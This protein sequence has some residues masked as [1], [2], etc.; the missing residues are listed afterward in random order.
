MDYEDMKHKIVPMHWD[1]FR[2]ML[3]VNEVPEPVMVRYFQIKKIIDKLSAP[4]SVMDLLRMAM[5]VGFNLE[6]GL[7]DTEEKP[8]QPEKIESHKPI[9][10]TK[11]KKKQ[12]TPKKS[13]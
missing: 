9:V 3:G 4:L 8:A 12:L 11:A 7:F 5:D 6:T 10:A 13:E 2:R 1:M